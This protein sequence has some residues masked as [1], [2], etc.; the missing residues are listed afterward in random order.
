MADRR[1]R[2]KAQAED[3]ERVLRYMQALQ[4]KKIPLLTLDAKWHA[5]FPDFR[6]TREIK[7]LEKEL[8]RLIE[9]QGQTANDLLD[10]KKA[11]KVMM[12]NVI[13]NMTDGHEFDSPI[14]VRKQEKNKQLI[15]EIND[16]IAKAKEDKFQFPAEIAAKNHELLI[17][18][19][20]VCYTELSDNTE[21]IE[22]AEAEITALR[23]QL[24]NTILHKQ[25][26]EMRNTEVYKYMHNLLGPDVVEIFDRDHRVWRG[27]MEE[28][29]LD[30]GGNNE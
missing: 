20:Q 29:H 25:D 6:K 30:A 2:R 10:Y 13:D 16:K 14:R 9:K 4:G 3:A 22:Q 23:E 15:E 7:R 27:N 5:L 26:M 17:A 28:N 21:R 19:M 24:K 12:Q 11:K 18:C 8:N 1:R